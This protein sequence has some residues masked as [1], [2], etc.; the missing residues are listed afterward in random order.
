[1]PKSSVRKFLLSI[2]FLTVIGLLTVVLLPLSFPVSFPLVFWFDQVNKFVLWLGLFYLNLK[3]LVPKVLYKGHNGRFFVFLL[4][5]ISVIVIIDNQY[6]RAVGLHQALEK[7]INKNGG[8]TV[9]T[10]VDFGLIIIS[11]M[12]AGVSTIAGVSNKIRNDQFQVQ[13]AEKEKVTAELSFLR[14]QINP[15]FFFNVLH[16]I[17]ALTET[18]T[19]KAQES[20]YTLSHMMRY[21]LYDTKNGTTTLDKEVAFIEDYA[22]LMQLRLTEKTQVTI[23]KT[24]ISKSTQIAPMLFLPF[25]ENAFKHGISSVY[26]SN[27]D[28]D[29]SEVGSV[30]NLEVRNSIFLEKADHMEESNGI[31]LTNTRRRLDLLYP[32]KYELKAGNDKIPNEFIVRLKLDLQ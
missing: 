25:V 30:L 21:V 17:Y 23:K 11:L 28:I 7:A 19:V 16:T 24:S 10:D 29:I 9:L 1:M 13:N 12:V 8:S 2:H 20:I 3:I 15:H 14:T 5:A 18:D 27:I 31:G 6:D 4:A 22:R 26:P 32:G